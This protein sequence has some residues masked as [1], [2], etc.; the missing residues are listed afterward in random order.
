MPFYISFLEQKKDIDHSS[1]LYS[2]KG[3]F[4]LIHADVANTRFFSKS[5]V[6]PSYYLLCVDLFSSNVYVYAMK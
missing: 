3:P 4:E 5:A 2:I 1:T 6:N